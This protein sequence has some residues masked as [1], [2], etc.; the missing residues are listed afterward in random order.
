MTGF[1]C[2]LGLRDQRMF[3]DVRHWDR[4]KFVR[5]GAVTDDHFFR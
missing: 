5:E 2:A 1:D 3:S 4:R